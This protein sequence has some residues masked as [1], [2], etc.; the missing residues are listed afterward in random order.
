M[1]ATLVLLLMLALNL[2]AIRKTQRHPQGCPRPS[3]LRVQGRFMQDLV[4]QERLMTKT[5]LQV[6]RLLAATSAASVGLLLPRQTLQ[7]IFS[8]RRRVHPHEP[9]AVALMLTSSVL[10]CFYHLK[11]CINLLLFSVI[12]K[13]F[14]Q[15]SRWLISR[16]EVNMER[17]V[18]GS[19]S[20]D[21]HSL[22]RRDSSSGGGIDMELRVL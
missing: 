17:L 14:R 19:P 20:S 3:R 22:V 4:D 15:A 5:Q 7:V 8:V 2:V 11:F 21:R 18:A 16:F 12:S 10:D 6:L 1:A 9:M 13:R